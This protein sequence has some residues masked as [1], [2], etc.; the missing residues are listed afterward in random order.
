[1]IVGSDREGEETDEGKFTGY[2][3]AEKPEGRVLADD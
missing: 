3:E 1:M 2:R